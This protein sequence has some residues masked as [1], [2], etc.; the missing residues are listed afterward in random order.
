MNLKL[1]VFTL[2]EL[3]VVIAIIAIL[4]S[5]LLPAL[6]KARAKAS[7]TLCMSNLKQSGLSLAMYAEDNNGWLPR[8]YDGSRVWTYW[9]CEGNYAPNPVV[10]APHIFVCPAY[11][12]EADK[13]GVWRDHGWSYGLN[14]SWST[15]ALRITSAT[16]RIQNGVNAGSAAKVPLLADGKHRTA[17][18]QD[19]RMAQGQISGNPGNYPI[20]A[21]HNKMCNILFADGH[22][23][24]FDKQA[25]IT[26]YY[27]SPEDVQY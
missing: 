14:R 22:V 16:V 19:Y 27:F 2:I 26:D 7:Q 8:T 4:A 23:D 20:H 21:R 18:Y 12:T 25:L 15:N 1:K 24:D 5:I 17:E 11:F 3:L 10:G 9:V 6:N 13:F